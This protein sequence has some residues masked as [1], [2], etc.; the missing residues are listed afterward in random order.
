SKLGKVEKTDEGR[1]LN[2]PGRFAA[3]SEKAI[4]GGAAALRTPGQGQG[5]QQH[6]QS[7]YAQFERNLNAAKDQLRAKADSG[8]LRSDNKGEHVKIY[9]QAV[10]KA[11]LEFRERVHAALKEYRQAAVKKGVIKGQPFY[12]KA[13]H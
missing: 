3:K 13:K 9:N 11:W 6:F 1:V 4:M 7:L 5:I 2:Q 10:D 8:E 12:I